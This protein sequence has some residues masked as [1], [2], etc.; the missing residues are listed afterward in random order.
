MYCILHFNLSFNV[1]YF[2]LMMVDNRQKHVA[3]KRVYS[4]VKLTI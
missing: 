3:L 4:F 1:C 2:S